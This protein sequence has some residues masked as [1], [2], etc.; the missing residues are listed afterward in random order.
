MRSTGGDLDRLAV[1]VDLLEY[2]NWRR[3]VWIPAV[4]AA[5]CTGAGF[6][7]LRR[8]NATTLV[9]GG[10]DVK[11]TQTRLGHADPRVTL[12]I[13][14]CAPAPVDRAAADILGRRFFGENC[15]SHSD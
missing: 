10:I 14:A 8:L 7:D 15:N 6:H 1:V 11:R 9:V 3:R 13:Y 5:G 4:T 12:S 2:S